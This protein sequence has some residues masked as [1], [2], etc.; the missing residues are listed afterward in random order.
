MH[1]TIEALNAIAQLA[2]FEM[3]FSTTDVLTGPEDGWVLVATNPVFVSVRSGSRRPWYVAIT[4]SGAPAAGLNG[5]AF[6]PQSQAD[7][8][9][10]RLQAAAA[11][12]CQV[13]VRASYPTAPGEKSRFSVIRDQA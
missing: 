10:F 2:E 7:G 6:D 5:Q 12:A 1:G 4:A 9:E 3:A 13:Y 11:T 8:N